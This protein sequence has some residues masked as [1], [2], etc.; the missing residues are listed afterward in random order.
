MDLRLRAALAVHLSRPH[1]DAP[2]DEKPVW[3][4]TCFFPSPRRIKA[5]GLRANSLAAAA[6]WAKSQGYGTL[7]G[8]PI[9]PRGEQYPPVFAWTGL[10]QA[11]E[12]GFTDCRVASKVTPAG[13][14]R[15]SVSGTE[16]HDSQY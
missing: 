11:F 15:W 7:G 4:V 8:Y 1:A 6:K 3:S 2:P 5:T 10:H 13:A 12:C 9:M 16:V 14:Q